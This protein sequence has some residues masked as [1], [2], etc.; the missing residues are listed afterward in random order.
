MVAI[1][2]ILPVYNTKRYLH[3]C[4]DSLLK[5]SY[6]NFEVLLI[7]D[8]STDGCEMICDAYA[9]TDKRVKVFHKENGGLSEAR[10][11]GL[12]ECRGEYIT[13]LDSD[14]YLDERY[15]ERLYKA[16]KSCKADFVIGQHKVIVEDEKGQ[17]RP[18]LETRYKG[19]ICH[20][21]KDGRGRII[22]K[23]EAYKYMLSGCHMTTSAWGKLYYRSLFQTIRYPVGE[24]YE[25]IKV[26]GSIVEKSRRIACLSYAG[27]YYV[28]RPGSITNGNISNEHMVLLENERK[29]AALIYQKY[30]AVTG[31]MKR[32][33]L[34]SCFF[35]FNGMVLVTDCEVQCRDLRRKILG[36]WRFL[37]FGKESTL[38]EIG[39]IISLIPGITCYRQVQKWIK[40]IYASGRKNLRMNG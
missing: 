14:D 7:D 6:R 31:V 32:H 12:V 18:I 4:L 26:I 1:S 11:K 8:G 24:L 10:N 28:Q 37:L 3:R 22:S 2:V 36:E 9:E 35:L 29:L 20:R 34:R 23:A 17:R 15:L 40:T 33:Y 5:Q 21:K 13:F 27:Y 25:D 30:P 19:N 38:V 16:A 39:M